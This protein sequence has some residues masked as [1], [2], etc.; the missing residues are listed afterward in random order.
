MVRSTLFW[1]ANRHAKTPFTK[2]RS[3]NTKKKQGFFFIIVFSLLRTKNAKIHRKY[4]KRGTEKTLREICIM[5]V[6][7]LQR[8]ASIPLYM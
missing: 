4:L 7:E 8:N 1:T 6:F 5:G 2:K 3:N